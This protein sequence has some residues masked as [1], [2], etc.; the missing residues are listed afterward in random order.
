[1]PEGVQSHR[2]AE[3][4]LRLLRVLAPL[5]ALAL[6][7][8]AAGFRSVRLAAVALM[9][10]AL[11]GQTGWALRHSRRG[12]SAQALHFVGWGLLAVAALGAVGVPQLAAT[13]VLLPALALVATLG[14]LQGAA[15]RRFVA[16]ALA[17]ET[18][19]VLALTLLPPA[20]GVARW[21]VQGYVLCAILCEASVLLVLQCES[22]LAMRTR[23]KEL[24]RSEARF[25]SLV[26]ASDS[27]VWGADA[28]GKVLPSEAW[29]AFTGQ[30]AQQSAGLGWVEALHPLDRA[31]TLHAWRE[32]VLQERP[33]LKDCRVR[34]LQGGYAWVR[35]RAAPV[36]GADG[37]VVEWMGASADVTQARAGEQRQR[38]LARVSAALVGTLEV[39]RLLQRIAHVVAP[40]LADA[41]VVRLFE[42]GGPRSIAVAHGDPQVEARMKVLLSQPGVAP[43]L[44]YGRTEETDGDSEQPPSHLLMEYGEVHRSRI[45]RVSPELVRQ[46]DVLAPR[47]VL[48]VTLRARRGAAL[49]ALTL[50]TLGHDGRRLTHEDLEAVEEVARRCSLALENALLYRQAQEA[51]RTREDFLA[52]ASH[53]L[54]TPLAALTL[55]LEGLTRQLDVSAPTP[56]DATWLRERV[57][58][59]RR[60]A[61]RLERLMEALLDV[62]RIAG[63]RLSLELERVDL[64][65]LVRETVQRLEEES[66]SAVR[67][68]ERVRLDAPA[69]VVGLWD[70]LR[71]E[72]A[73]E[74]LVGN[75][76]KYGERGPVD[77]AVSRNGV[78]ALLEVVDHGLGIP[79]EKQA[80]IWEK[81]ERHVSGRHYGGLGL[82]LYILREV[83]DAMGGSVQVRSQPGEGA[84]F[85]VQL[86]LDGPPLRPGSRPRAFTES[87]RDE[88]LRGEGG[89]AAADTTH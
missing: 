66:G 82:G 36:R 48:S 71:V 89:G 4:Y 59:L 31:P 41:C 7:A 55:S 54:R 42:A 83:V 11:V 13:G 87:A 39:E 40:R 57:A 29:Q 5:F 49:G 22:R 77:V 34:R 68:A 1:M 32:A 74:S 27:V 44:L 73:V 14:A 75:A 12:Q 46:L 24:A 72:Q 6:S 84:A 35:V 10:W 9:V 78:H 52:V 16:A 79:E 61:R 26:E 69:P 37:R 58:R 88:A 60:H 17:A 3:R 28:Q 18:V 56:P 19:V 50:L 85:T 51:V 2:P 47:S 65:E 45:A 30:P 33:F 38:L 43:L 23:L 25:R 21:F 8:G 15:L 62:S 53:E 76:L 81:F 86:P 63:G 67:V 80:S 20:A 70:R 64:A